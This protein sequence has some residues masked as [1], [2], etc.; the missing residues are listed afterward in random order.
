MMP[1]APVRH[2]VPAHLPRIVELAAEHAAYE[3]SPPPVP[4]LAERLDVLLF[5]SPEPTLR[6]LVAQTPDGEVV[7]Y[8]TCAPQISTWDG[9]AYLHMDCLFLRSGTRG[10]G[11]GAR[12]MDAV[13]AEARALGLS[14]VQWQT[15]AWNEGAIRF[16]SRLGAEAREKLRFTLD[17]GD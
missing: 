17:L 15:P 13:T 6:C 16:Y 3:K 8:A 9:R 11:L 10:R 4:D 14:E 2:A 7:G 1:E 12:L 5:G